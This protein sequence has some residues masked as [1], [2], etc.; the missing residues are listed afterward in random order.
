MTS[1]P[2]K[3]TNEHQLSSRQ[4][5]GIFH[6]MKWNFKW[7]FCIRSRKHPWVTDLGFL[8]PGWFPKFLYQM[9][10]L[11]G[12]LK[13]DRSGS[14]VYQLCVTCMYGSSYKPSQRFFWE[15]VKEQRNVLKERLICW[16]KHIKGWIRNEKFLKSDKTQTCVWTIL[17][18]LSLMKQNCIGHTRITH[19]KNVLSLVIHKW[20]R[21]ADGIWFR[22]HRTSRKGQ[23]QS[24]CS[25]GQ[26]VLEGTA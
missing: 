7:K 12:V 3:T 24:N 18:F 11:G 19:G 15:L 13:C 16:I 22:K 23:S 25:E 26:Q 14:C 8:Y 9:C 10:K 1:G 17:K 4:S 20:W 2:K 6:W 5:G 21:T